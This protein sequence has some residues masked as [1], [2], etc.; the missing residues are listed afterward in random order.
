MST[1][2][3]GLDRHDWESRWHSFEEELGDDPAAALPEIA[4]L[5]ESMLVD[6]GYDLNDPVVRDGDEREVVAEY[7][8]ARDTSDRVE[9]GETVD[10]GDVGAAVT[11]LRTVFEYLLSERS[12]N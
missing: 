10:P 4:D 11:G 3:P 9:R 2:E 1:M 5:V 12:A 8:A 7:R 6:V